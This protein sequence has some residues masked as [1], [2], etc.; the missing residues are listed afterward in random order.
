MVEVL[1]T[2]PTR[3]VHALTRWALDGGRRLGDLTVTRPSLE[4]VYLELVGEAPA[5]VRAAMPASYPAA[6]PVPDPAADPV[7]AERGDA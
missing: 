3:D 4:D 5:D 7:P 2:D 6:D 1:T